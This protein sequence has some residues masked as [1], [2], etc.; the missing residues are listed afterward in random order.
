MNGVHCQQVEVV[1]E[2]QLFEQ[3]PKGTKTD[4]E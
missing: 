3:S 1:Y 4:L 2:Q